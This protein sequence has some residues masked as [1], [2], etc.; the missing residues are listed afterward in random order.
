LGIAEIIIAKHRNGEVRDVSMRFR[1]S[2]AKFL[3]MNDP[4][5]H[6]PEGLVTYGSRMNSETISPNTD[7]DQF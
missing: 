2:E 7:F 5:T 3:D 1:E 6:H 4:E